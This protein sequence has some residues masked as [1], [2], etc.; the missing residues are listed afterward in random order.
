M[1]FNVR[2]SLR[3]QSLNIILGIGIYN[4]RCTFIQSPPRQLSSTVIG[5][6]YLDLTTACS[7]DIGYRLQGWLEIVRDERSLVAI[8]LTHIH[9]GRRYL[10]RWVIMRG[11]QGWQPPGTNNEGLLHAVI[12]ACHLGYVIPELPRLESIKE[13]QFSGTLEM[14]RSRGC[15]RTLH[16]SESRA[17]SSLVQ[18]D[19][20]RLKGGMS[21]DPN[22]LNKVAI[23]PA[24]VASKKL[25]AITRGTS[26][27]STVVNRARYPVPER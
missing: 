4:E 27:R 22:G 12:C 20:D 15:E 8:F 14:M 1:A 13:S 23:S 18:C 3:I 16:M 17:R 5:D 2:A 11:W 9:P 6:P 21:L 19:K 25:P 7:P 26:V 24:N 10:V